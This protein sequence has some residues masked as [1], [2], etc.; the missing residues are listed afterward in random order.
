MT[1]KVLNEQNI[2]GFFAIL[3]G[4]LSLYEA[5]KLN[6]FGQGLLIGDHVFPGL[7]GILLVVF[8][9]S[10]VFERKTDRKKADLVNQKTR[11]VLIASIFILLL[12]SFL[13]AAVGYVI[14]TLLVSVSLIRLIGNYR[15]LISILIGGVITAVF[16]LLFIILLKT[17]LP[18]GIFTL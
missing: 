18:I 10:L 9:I 5:S 4:L 8:G 1:S 15:W 2:G 3:F 13:I 6:S 14:S 16:Y 17:P 11:K 7:I 12:Y